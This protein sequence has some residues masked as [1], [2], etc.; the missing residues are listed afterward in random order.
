[1][2]PSKVPQCYILRFDIQG[3][4][5]FE[6]SLERLSVCS[7]RL[8][9]CTTFFDEVLLKKRFKRP[10]EIFIC[11]HFLY[12]FCFDKK[13]FTISVI[14]IVVFASIANSSGKAVGVKRK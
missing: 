2:R 12:T 8:L 6:I 5:I 11:I 9:A 13:R 4:I 1:M 10:R 3:F 7:Y 14:G